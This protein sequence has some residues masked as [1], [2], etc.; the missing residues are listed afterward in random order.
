MDRRLIKIAMNSRYGISKPIGRGLINNYRK[1]HGLPLFRKKNKKKR[2]YS[3][4]PRYELYKTM[5]QLKPLCMCEICGRP[6]AEVREDI[7]IHPC[8]CDTC[9]TNVK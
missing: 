5:M 3:R 9:Y 2:R 8:L 1:M 4:Y 6:Y 7:Y